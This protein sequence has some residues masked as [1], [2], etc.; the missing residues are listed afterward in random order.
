V[1]LSYDSLVKTKTDAPES[2]KFSN[3][4][5]KVLKVSHAELQSRIQADKQARKQ[6]RKHSSVSRASRAKDLERRFSHL[7]SDLREGQPLSRY[8]R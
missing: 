7:A 5:R 8:L 1:E 2:V 3:A 4:L 6:R